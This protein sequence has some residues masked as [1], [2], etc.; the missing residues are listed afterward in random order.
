MK[1]RSFLA[2]ALLALAL[3]GCS[4]SLNA[5]ADDAVPG[6]E[7]TVAK[8]N[9]N[10]GVAPIGS[11]PHGRTYGEWAARWWQW[12]YSIPVSSNPLLDET[13]VHATVGQAGK[14][15]F[16]CGV[17][18]VSGTASRVI[19]VPSGTAL[20]FPILNF[21][22]D[23]FWPVQTPPYDVLGLRA[24]AAAQMDGVS[25]MSCE[26]DGR[27]LRDLASYRT[28]S[29]VF[30]VTMPVDNIPAYFGFDTPAGEY[31]P[32]VDDG[33]YL[34]LEP[35]SAGTHQLHF[36]GTAPGRSRSTSATRST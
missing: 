16:L 7:L 2:L 3:P 4:K 9:L 6:G 36:S 14:V 10:P 34:F 8:A 29:P 32:I 21:E 22:A 26:L 18:N 15:W 35:L 25:N 17:I 27:A 5:P 23:N 1:G 13:G 28:R 30:G 33:Y 31:Q 19:E 11:S 20:F 12:A 24:L